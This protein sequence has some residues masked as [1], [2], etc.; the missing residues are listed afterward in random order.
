MLKINFIISI[1][2]NEPGL[3]LMIQ[4]VRSQCNISSDM[5]K[6]VVDIQRLMDT[7]ISPIIKL[8]GMYVPALN[9][10]LG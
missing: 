5:S 4:Q 2:D 1:K 3:A 8:T 6:K 7:Y 10:T 9:K